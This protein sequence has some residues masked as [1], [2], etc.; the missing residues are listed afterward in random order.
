M[1]TL[2][3]IES[4]KVFLGMEGSIYILGLSHDIISK[5]IDLAY[6]KSGVTGEQYIK[7]DNSNSNKSAK[8]E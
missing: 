8:V 7:K 2:E 4:I 5:L 6:E 3:V 1:K